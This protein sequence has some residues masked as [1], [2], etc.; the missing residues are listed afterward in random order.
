M[1]Y[2]RANEHVFR[3][4]ASA[5][6][7]TRMNIVNVRM[8][9]SKH[10]LHRGSQGRFAPGKLNSLL[11]SGC[12]KFARS[13]ISTPSQLHGSGVLLGDRDFQIAIPAAEGIDHFLF[14]VHIPQ[15][16]LIS[17]PEHVAHIGGFDPDQLPIAGVGYQAKLK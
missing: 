2:C 10:C 8:T 9:V 17:Q 1:A 16:Q 13:F 14:P 12:S 7:K 6:I 4:R 5:T 15:I 3:C 11:I